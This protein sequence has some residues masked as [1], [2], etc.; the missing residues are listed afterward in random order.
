MPKSRKLK[1]GR[2]NGQQR[3]EEKGKEE[4]GLGQRQA[5][6]EEAL[7]MTSIRYKCGTGLE[8]TQMKELIALWRERARLLR[9]M[10]VL[11]ADN[12]PLSKNLSGLADGYEHCAVELENKETVKL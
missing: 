5:R 2:S 8:R 4:T 11:I 10:V 9:E 7:Q 6:Q 3:Q 12:K 1:G